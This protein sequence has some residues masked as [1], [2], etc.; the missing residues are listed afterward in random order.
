MQNFMG[1]QEIA[2]RKISVVDPDYKQYIVNLGFQSGNKTR[3]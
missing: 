1:I 3:L 2:V